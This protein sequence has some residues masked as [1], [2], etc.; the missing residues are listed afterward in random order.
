MSSGEAP[1]AAADGSTSNNMVGSSVL[2]CSRPARAQR[3]NK[4]TSPMSAGVAFGATRCRFSS[5]VNVRG[6]YSTNSSI[7]PLAVRSRN[8]LK[9]SGA[10]GAPK[11]DTF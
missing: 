5:P 6:M 7:T 11:F 1:P 9:S 4:I 10:I 2:A 8:A 3:M